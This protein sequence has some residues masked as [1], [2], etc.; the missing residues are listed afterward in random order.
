MGTSLN[1]YKK[2]STIGRMC[3]IGVGGYAI[4]ILKDS[5]WSAAEQEPCC[6]IINWF[7]KYITHSLNHHCNLTIGIQPI[8]TEIPLAS[9]NPLGFSLILKMSV[10]STRILDLGIICLGVLVEVAMA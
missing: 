10:Q 8:G 5:P 7:Y 1:G 4:N 6:I 9:S 3:V 2:S